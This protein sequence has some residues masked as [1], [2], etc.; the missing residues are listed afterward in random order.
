MSD[1][2]GTTH[3][4]STLQAMFTQNMT[5][6]VMA[7]NTNVIMTFTSPNT[8]YGQFD[9]LAQSG[10][11]NDSISS[12]FLFTPT[13][14][15]I[16]TTVRCRLITNTAAAFNA[17]GLSSNHAVTVNI[18]TRWDMLGISNKVAS[19]TANQSSSFAAPL[20]FIT[21]G[22]SST[23]I[24][25]SLPVISNVLA[26][27]IANNTAT[28]QWTTDV[29]SDSQVLY[30]TNPA[31]VTNQ[32]SGGANV[33]NH[34]VNLTGLQQGT[35]Y[36]FSVSSTSTG[37]TTTDDNQGPTTRSQ[38]RR[39]IR[40]KASRR[41]SSSWRK[42]RTGLRSAAMRRARTSITAC[43]QSPHTPHSITILPAST[44][45]CRTICGWRRARTLASWPTATP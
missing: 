2:N 22:V 13:N 43:C 40:H 5:A 25:S 35:P 45:V 30:G 34:V 23:G 42:T 32:A 9:G 15:A 33:T 14:P 29:Q 20:E 6:Q 31:A 26:M 36:Y 41:S 8:N 1:P 10:V 4:G 17:T 19:L 39:R 24:V 21:L 16:A 37:G 18:L 3:A 27:N 28:I 11:L 12:Y 38:P 7:D 44:P